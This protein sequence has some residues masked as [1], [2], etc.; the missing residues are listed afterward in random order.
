MHAVRHGP[1]ALSLARLMTHSPHDYEPTQPVS[2][3]GGR[4]MH[5]PSCNE[6]NCQACH[7]WHD[8]HYYPNT[9]LQN[10]QPAPDPCC[11]ATCAV[12]QQPQQH[13]TR[14]CTLTL[15]HEYMPDAMAAACILLAPAPLGAAW[16]QA[17]P[18][19]GHTCTSGPGSEHWLPPFAGCL[20]A[21]AAGSTACQQPC[22]WQHH[23]Q[24]VHTAHCAVPHH[25]SLTQAHQMPEPA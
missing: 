7:R 25:A 11:M 14:Q 19:C 8:E 22:T 3:R 9:A 1:P 24:M 15:R 21:G 6:Q 18:S 17:Q 4:G 23:V 12:Q 2:L 16:G 10:S 20:L 5:M 13:G